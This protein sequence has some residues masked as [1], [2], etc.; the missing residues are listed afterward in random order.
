MSTKPTVD[1]ICRHYQARVWRTGILAM[2]SIIGL[3]AACFAVYQ[4]KHAHRGPRHAVN[5]DASR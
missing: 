5:V 1:P 2:I 4:T 3:S